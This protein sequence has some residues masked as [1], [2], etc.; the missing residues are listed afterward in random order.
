MVTKASPDGETASKGADGAVEDGCGVTVPEAVSP[1]GCERLV[2]VSS[3]CRMSVEPTASLSI[4][5]AAFSS[6]CP[7]DEV[8]PV[9]RF[10][11]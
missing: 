6:V 7:K 5:T 3:L 8:P 10:S 11:N 9:G 1:S 2:S 4:S